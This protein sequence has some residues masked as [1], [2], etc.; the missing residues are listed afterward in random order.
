MFFLCIFI[1]LQWCYVDGVREPGCTN[2]GWSYQVS[3]PFLM[4]CKIRRI[5]NFTWVGYGQTCSKLWNL[6]H[7]QRLCNIRCAQRLCNVRYAQRLCNVRYAQRLCNV[8]YAQR[9]CNVRYAQRLCNV[10]YAERLCN[11]K[12]AKG[13]TMWDMLKCYAMWLCWK[14]KQ[15]HKIVNC[16]KQADYIFLSICTV[17]DQRTRHSV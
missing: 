15:A 11:M 4:L 7:A 17:I 12:Y 9:L 6:G 8:G 14:V 13:Y 3:R 16:I 10:G 5:K 1:S 2:V